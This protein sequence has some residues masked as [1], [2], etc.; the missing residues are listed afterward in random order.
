MRLRPSPARG[1]V[2]ASTKRPHARI[3]ALADRLRRPA[4]DQPPAVHDADAIAQRHRLGH[5]V[6]D[7]DHALAQA[8]LNAPELAP[9]AGGA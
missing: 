1:T 5:V 2:T 3:L 6:R 9:A 8:R 4:P 7:E